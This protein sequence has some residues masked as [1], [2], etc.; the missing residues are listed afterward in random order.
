MRLG[1][2]SLQLALAALAVTTMF[3]ASAASAADTEDN[4]QSKPSGVAAAAV[5]PNQCLRDGQVGAGDSRVSLTSNVPYLLPNAAGWQTLKCTTTFFTVPRGQRAGVDLGLSGEFDASGPASNTGWV[6]GRVVVTPASAASAVA[7]VLPDNDGR[8]DSFALDASKSGLNDWSAH[9]LRQ[10][11]VVT[12]SQS[13][14]TN[15]PCVFRVYAQAQLTA[16]ANYLWYD[17]TTLTV[18]AYN[19]TQHGAPTRVAVAP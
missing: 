14:T 2:R 5:A 18:N 11:T 12:C 6:Q 19:S 7:A 17:D 16:G 1:K 13:S 10:S 4:A 15:A 8:G 3:G 9:V